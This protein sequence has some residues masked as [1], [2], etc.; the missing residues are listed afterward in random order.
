MNAAGSVLSAITYKVFVRRLFRMG[1]LKRARFGQFLR[2]SGLFSRPR[3]LNHVS[4][5]NQHLPTKTSTRPDMEPSSRDR[6]I[7]ITQLVNGSD[8]FDSAWYLNQYPDVAASGHHPLS[9]F[10]EHGWKEGRDPGP[11]FHATW[12][13]HQYPDV[14][15][16]GVNPLVH[17]LVM[18]QAEGR[19]PTK[20]GRNVLP[21]DAYFAS[22]L[23]DAKWYAKSNPDLGYSSE[24]DLLEHYLV[25]GWKESRNPSP[26]FY[27]HWYMTR[28][29]H[30]LFEQY[31]P[32]T[33][34]LRF[35]QKQNYLPAPVDVGRILDTVSQQYRDLKDLEPDLASQFSETDAQHLPISTKYIR[36]AMELCWN[37]LF[38]RIPH[39]YQ[40]IIFVPWLI[41]GGADL[42]AI[43][44]MRAYIEQAGVQSVLMVATDS[45]RDD[46]RDWL[47]DGAAFLSYDECLAAVNCQTPLSFEDRVHLTATLIHSLRPQAILNVN[48]RACWETIE[49]YGTVLG[50]SS[51]LNAALFCRDFDEN[52]RSAGY[53]QTYFRPC[54][55]HLS[56]VLFDNARFREELIQEFFVP[57]RLQSRLQVVY[58]PWTTA[59]TKPVPRKQNPQTS[60]ILW[61]ARIC[62]QK[63][64]DIL[65]EVVR[66]CPELEFDIHGVGDEAVRQPLKDFASQ[67]PNARLLEPFADFGTLP[68]QQYCAFLHTARW[69]GLPNALLQAAGYGIPIVASDVG[70]ISE[71]VDDDTGWLIRDVENPS[72]Y[73][74]AL[75][76]IHN[77]PRIVEEKVANML[78]RIRQRHGWS[79]YLQQMGV[80]CPA[81]SG[82]EL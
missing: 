65:M 25:Y 67:Q 2:A 19:L 74:E 20:L 58:Q 79:N 35:G 21:L 16:A 23:F 82:G 43:Y 72:A 24:W 17:Y 10:L 49:R 70:G 18:G 5:A 22:G 6:S 52:G 14:A 28:Y 11:G 38:Q 41:R 51:E 50:Q 66:R 46:A 13:L 62:R 53:S 63:A 78:E 39:L 9:H 8:L 56:N 61:G 4:Q 30:V 60:R 75:R 36:G 3:H 31:D 33:H 32:L 34:Y 80:P 37:E 73:A 71:L 15:A 68:H 55:H 12:Y 69:E 27:T 45:D 76:F 26:L 29:A 42:E 40:R 48:S 59:P 44:A 77:H 64:P 81:N 54:L 57:E 7:D 47:P 1:N